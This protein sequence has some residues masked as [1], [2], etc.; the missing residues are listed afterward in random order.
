MTYTY[1]I[2]LLSCIP[3]RGVNRIWTKQLYWNK[4][5]ITCTNWQLKIHG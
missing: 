3:K 4:I 1:Q 5:H 2:I